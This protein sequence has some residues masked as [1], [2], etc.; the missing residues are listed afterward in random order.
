[1]RAAAVK[2]GQPAPSTPRISGGAVYDAIVALAAVDHDAELATRDARAKAT[3]ETV[4]A[5][6]VI[7]GMSADVAVVRGTGGATAPTKLTA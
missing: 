7:A 2:A 3:Y 6:V 1:V 4:G 5:R